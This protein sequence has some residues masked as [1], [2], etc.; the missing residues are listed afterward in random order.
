MT[1][2]RNLKSDDNE[3]FEGVFDSK[4]LIQ[5]EMD[6]TIF[7]VADG[8]KE[9]AEKCVDHYNNLNKNQKALDDIQEMLANFMFYM[10]DEWKEM[11]F[12][13]IAADTE[14]AI[15][16][17]DAG[18]PLV[19]CLSNPRFYIDFLDDE[20]IFDEIGYIIEADCPWEPEHQCCIIIRG[21]EVKYVGTS[22]GNTPWDDDDEYYCVWNDEE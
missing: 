3:S 5:E 9:Y 17:Y 22:N 12:D 2:I 8:V 13:D 15:E 1:A 11:G 18:K 16:A 20:P 10:Y 19:S 4:S 7:S 14:K 6:I 21:D